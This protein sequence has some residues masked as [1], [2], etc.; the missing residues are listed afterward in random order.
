MSTK[1]DNYSTVN[2]F[3]RPIKINQLISYI[4]VLSLFIVFFAA[5]QNNYENQTTRITIIILFVIDFL[6]VVVTALIASKIDPADSIMLIYRNGDKN[7]IIKYLDQ[8]LYC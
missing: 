7:E 5:I 1:Q 4:L 2:T 8:C 3:S 6:T